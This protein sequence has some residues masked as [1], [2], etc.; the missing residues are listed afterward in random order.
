MYATYFNITVSQDKPSL[1]LTGIKNLK[2]TDYLDLRKIL[3][4]LIIITLRI[5]CHDNT[6]R[7]EKL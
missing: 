1:V 5:M 2:K 4:L 6:E 7:L 3:L